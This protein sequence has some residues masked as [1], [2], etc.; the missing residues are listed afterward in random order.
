MKFVKRVATLI[1]M[2]NILVLYHTISY[3]VRKETA[4]TGTKDRN[5]EVVSKPR[6]GANMVKVDIIDI[7]IR[8]AQ[9]GPLL[10]DGID[11]LVGAN[12]AKK[13]NQPIVAKNKLTVTKK[14]KRPTAAKKDN[15]PTASN[16]AK[17]DNP[18]GDANVKK[19]DHVTTGAPATTTD[20]EPVLCT[21]EPELENRT[22]LLITNNLTCKENVDLLILVTTHAW[23]GQRRRMAIRETWGPYRP[24]NYNTSMKIWQTFFVV[25]NKVN[26]T[27]DTFRQ[28]FERTALRNEVDYYQDMIEGNFE[29]IFYNLPYKLWVAF[30]W[31]SLYCNASYI[32]KTDDDVFVNTQNSFKFLSRMKTTELYTGHVWWNSEVERSGKYKVEYTECNGTQYPPFV[33]GSS[34][35]FSRDVIHSLA[36]IYPQVKVFKLDDVHIGILMYKLGIN[37]TYSNPGGVRLWEVWLPKETDD[38]CNIYKHAVVRHI[39]GKNKA[40]CVHKLF[41]A[42]LHHIDSYENITSVDLT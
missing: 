21:T 14:D 1:C 42:S 18:S 27:K 26:K 8:N 29:E 15:P 36:N 16:V 7:M 39:H 34:M 20:K 38:V 33:S 30:E 23:T 32:L 5:V 22:S 37:A 6:E 3:I 25:G 41:H 12:V 4:F 13:E 40:W 24:T 35:F 11:P 9:A 2:G 31:A 10:V 17:G 28:R 19:V